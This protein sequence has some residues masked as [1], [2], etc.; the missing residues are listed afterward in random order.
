MKRKSPIKKYLVRYIKTTNVKLVFLINMINREKLYSKAIIF[1][2]GLFF[3][4]GCECPLPCSPAADPLTQLLVTILFPPTPPF[5]G[6]CTLQNDCIDFRGAMFE[7]VHANICD[8]QGGIY[9]SNFRCDLTGKSAECSLL[10]ET[11][12]FRLKYY[13][14]VSWD[15]NSSLDHCENKLKGVYSSI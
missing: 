10:K 2:F 7:S 8:S 11:T 14:N 4:N 3:A 15:G 9:K 13:Y 1:L 5:S 12:L 6:S